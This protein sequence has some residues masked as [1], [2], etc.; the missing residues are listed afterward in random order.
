MHLVS[1]IIPTYGR[2][3]RLKKALNSALQQ[4]YRNIQ[5]IVVDD[6]PPNS[7]ARSETENLLRDFI[8]KK[9][10]TYIQ[11]EENGGGSK[12]R[13]TGIHAAS[14][15][16]ITFLDDD[17]EYLPEKIEKQ[18]SHLIAEELDISLCGMQVMENG[19]PINKDD[20]MP[21]GKSLKEFIISG[22]VYTPMI[23][24]TREL[25][26]KAGGF[27]DTPRFQDH[28]LMI[29]LLELAPK[30]GII[31]RKLF[32]HNIHTGERI[33]YS[34]KSRLGFINKHNHENKHSKLLTKTEI[35][36]LRARQRLALFRLDFSHSNNH[37][38]AKAV[39]SLIFSIQSWQ[40]FMSHFRHFTKALKRKLLFSR[41]HK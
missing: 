3:V 22:N 5:I 28:I 31:N 34:P 23:M 20:D 36:N 29:R 11:R 21:T 30:V 12:A 15:D 41:N 26:I 10:I 2:P 37:K 13:N 38:K 25:I 14:G 32:I 27:F 6:N 8:L 16:F 1:I 35:N 4:T 7:P 40:E 9:Q 33:T 39:T 19:A 24:T 18:V 17:D